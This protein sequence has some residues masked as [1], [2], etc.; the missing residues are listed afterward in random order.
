MSGNLGGFKFVKK[1]VLTALMDGGL[2][3]EIYKPFPVL[4][5]S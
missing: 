5:A 2:T 4:P 1:C 3:G